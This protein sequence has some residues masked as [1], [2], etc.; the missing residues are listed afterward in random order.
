MKNVKVT[1][2]LSEK[3]E[4]RSATAASP[5]GV[6]WMVEDGL[7]TILAGDSP[8]VKVFACALSR[9]VCVER[10]N[11]EPSEKEG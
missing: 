4:L 7:L 3:S 11:E 8:A 5:S 9:V 1:Y 6:T 2:L 10:T